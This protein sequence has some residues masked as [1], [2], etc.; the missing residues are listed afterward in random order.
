MS[1]KIL[2]YQ[3]VDDE[4]LNTI[5]YYESISPAL[6]LKFEKNIEIAFNELEKN[7]ENYF[8]LE[9]KKHRRI[10]IDKFP[11]ALIYCIQIDTVIIKMLFPLLKNPTKL[12]IGIR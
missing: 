4:I 2:K 3:I 9:D 11:Y 10:I 6:G 1:F 5:L 8:N 12:W 7:P